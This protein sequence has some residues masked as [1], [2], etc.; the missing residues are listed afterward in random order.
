MAFRSPR[1]A[2]IGAGSGAIAV[3]LAVNA[4]DLTVYATDVSG[5]ALEVAA[6]NVWR[7]GVGEQ[8]QLL[9]GPLLDPLPEPV[10]II[11]A[12]LPYVAT[13]D[14]PH[15]PPQVRDFEPL[16]AL[17]GGPGGLQVIGKLL[18]ALATPA[19]R[20]KLR[21]G[22]LVYLEIGAGQGAAARELAQLL[23]PDAEVEQQV[24]Y[25]GLDRLLIVAL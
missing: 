21:P 16:L 24:D 17:D 18:A 4:P 23:L 14:L 12:N 3:A 8:V 20:A 19:G 2:D 1:V 13:G 11:V 22:G 7:Y 25:S 6:Q 10:D 5:D 15:L 9:P